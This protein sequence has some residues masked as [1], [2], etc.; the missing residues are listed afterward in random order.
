MPRTRRFFSVLRLAA[1]AALAACGAEGGA[2]KAGS[3]FARTVDSLVA[4]YREATLAPGVSVAVIRAGRDTLV[5]RGYGVADLE[6]DAPATPETVYRIGSLTK[7][8]TA[9]AVM[10]FVEQGR[11]SLDD[12][13][14]RHLPGLPAAWRGARIRQLLNHT[15]GIP[16][17]SADR[18]FARLALGEAVPD[19]VIALVGDQPLDFAPGTKWR[20]SNTGYTLLGLLIERLSG[21]PYARWMESRILRPLGLAATRYCGV[22]PVIPHRA[23]GYEARGTLLVNARYTSML[24]PYAGGGLCS[25]VGDM[26]AWNRALATGR[27]V[28]PASWARMT[29]PEGPARA[30]GYGY[31]IGTRRVAGHR[32]VRHA[33][34]VEG[35]RGDNLY[36]V[37]DSLSVTVLT[38]LAAPGPGP[39]ATQIVRAALPSPADPAPPR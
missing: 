9:A 35:F 5:Y 14:A 38:N 30:A 33:G 4:G 15:A 23:E 36:L 34:G 22:E 19:S 11:V 10:R 7:Q 26:A 3:P 6:H 17:F 27:V 32:A 1:V 37:D 29:T 21:E 39:L 28:S 24:A 8:F 13:I 2:R 16:E 18:R 12:S 20:Y 31:G 25:T